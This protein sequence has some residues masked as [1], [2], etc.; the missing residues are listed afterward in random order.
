[1]ELTQATRSAANSRQETVQAD[2]RSRAARQP[3]RLSLRNR[4]SVFVG[5]MKLLLPAMAAA[6]ILLVVA[7]PQF[8]I[9]DGRFRLSVSKLAPDQAD[10]LT[11]L[12][13]RFDGMD[14]RD[15][16]YTITADMA[17]QSEGDKDLIE[18]ELPK[19]DVT[20]E[21][22]AWLALTARSGEYRRQSRLLDLSGSVS[23]FHDKGFE[24]RTEAARVDLG[25]GVAEGAQPVQ[26]QG[27][28][29]FI[30]AEGFRVLN[31]GARI[32]F[33]GKSHLIVMPE[34]RESAR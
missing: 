1:V 12:N 32:L 16:P 11:M 33:T 15:Q 8:T 29:G 20:L 9:E 24:L 19:A 22:G 3:Q 26:G 17:T 10:N 7:W 28:A 5:F 14:E 4:Y 13:A 30:E 6:L 34:A 25:N 23:L 18:L 2:R 21:D 31:R 27:S